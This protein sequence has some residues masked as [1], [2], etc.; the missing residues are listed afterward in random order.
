MGPDRLIQGI[1]VFVLIY[2]LYLTITCPCRR[3]LSCHTTQ[4]KICLTIIFT[5]VLYE[6]FIKV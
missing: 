4:T 5:I 2:M 3:L 6:N 1:M